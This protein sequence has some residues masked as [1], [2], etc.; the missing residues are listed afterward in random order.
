MVGAIVLEPDGAFDVDGLG[1]ST[2]LSSAAATGKIPATMAMAMAARKPS[3]AVNR[4]DDEKRGAVF[5]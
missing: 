4:D 1:D 5:M 3:N 2:V